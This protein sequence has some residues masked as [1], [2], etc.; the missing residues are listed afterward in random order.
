MK[1]NKYENLKS[2]E[3]RKTKGKGNIPFQGK[4]KDDIRYKRKKI[5]NNLLKGKIALDKALLKTQEDKLS[6]DKSQQVKTQKMSHSVS[7]F[8]TK[9]LFD[10]FFSS[11]KP[12]KFWS[13]HFAAPPL[14]IILLFSSLLFSSLLFS[15]LLFSS[16]LPL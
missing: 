3:E 10:Y 9:F 15:S 1:L 16:L 5:E 8:Q 12:F 4:M 6:L 2:L 14:E 13:P 11:K 7:S